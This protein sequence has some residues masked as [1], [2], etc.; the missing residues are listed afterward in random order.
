METLSIYSVVCWQLNVGLLLAWCP[1]AELARTKSEHWNIRPWELI[2]NDGTMIFTISIQGY[3][4]LQSL[5]IIHNCRRKG[6]VLRVSEFFCSCY[7]HDI[8]DVMQICGI[9]I[10]CTL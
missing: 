5:I 3:F 6:Y 1:F 9:S 8:Y 10:A 4:N 7:L 2:G